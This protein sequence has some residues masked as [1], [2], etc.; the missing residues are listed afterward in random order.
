MR[1]RGLAVALELENDKTASRLAAACQKE[2]QLLTNAGAKIPLIPPPLEVEA[3]LTRRALATI[4]HLENQLPSL[5][6][7]FGAKIRSNLS[8]DYLQPNGLKS[9]YTLSV[10]HGADYSKIYTIRLR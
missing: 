2:G 4:K 8:P 1:I 7:T 6:K 3:T 10:G 9:G 5:S